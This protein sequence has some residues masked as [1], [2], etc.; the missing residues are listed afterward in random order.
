MASRNS[1]IA[2]EGWWLLAGISAAGCILYTLVGIIGAAPALFALTFLLY[3]FRDP[4]R[5]PPSLPLALLSPIHGRVIGIGRADNPWLKRD[6]VKISMCMSLLD[7]G[8][9]YSPTEGKIKEQWSRAHSPGQ[10]QA[11][12]FWI[13]TDEGDDVVVEISRSSWGGPISFHGSPGER[14]G[15]GAR[16]G[17]AFWGCD[18]VIYMPDNSEI[19]VDIGESLVGAMTTVGRLVHVKPVSAIVSL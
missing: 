6:S 5:I 2:G 1:I 17:Y 9:I 12:A 7:I 3:V 10:S 11:V 18:V 15:H 16:M 4:A 14:V 19:G 8:S 13:Q